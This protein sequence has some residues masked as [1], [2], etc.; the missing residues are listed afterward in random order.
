MIH[1]THDVIFCIEPF[2]I[3]SNRFWL[4]KLTSV[5][6]SYLSNRLR[7]GYHESKCALTEMYNHNAIKVSK[8]ID[9]VQRLA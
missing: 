9:F 5:F 2:K 4:I 7:H 1:F 3:E 6:F 8:M